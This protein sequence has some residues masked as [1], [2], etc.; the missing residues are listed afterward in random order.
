MGK[1]EKKETK[2]PPSDV[3]DTLT[4]DAQQAATC[5]LMLE[6]GEEDVLSK[7]CEALYKFVEKGDE[8]KKTLLDLGA[9]D[10]LLKLLQHDDRMV[11][12]NACMVFGLMTSHPDVRKMLRKRED[13]IPCLI[14]LISPE[15]DTLCHEFSA[16]ALSSLS[17]DYANKVMIYEN[18][19]MEAL[20]RCLGASDPDVQKNSVDA[21]SSLLQDFQARTAIRD[22]NGIAPILELTKSEYPVIQEIALVALERLTQDAENRAA[23]RELNGLT[24][25]VQFIGN[26]EFKDLHVFA[27]VVLSNC[28][29]DLES[30][31]TIKESGGLTKLVAYITDIPPPEDDGEKKKAGGKEKGK[32]AKSDKKGKVEETELVPTLPDVKQHAAKAIGRAAKSTEN[33]KVLHEAEVEKMFIHLFNHED[34]KVQAAAVEALGVM[35]EFG[36]SRD[37][38]SKWEGMEPLVKML[39]KEDLHELLEAAT[40]ALANLT[41]GSANN[42][43]EIVNFGGVESLIALLSH[44]KDTVIS[45][46]CVI[47]TNMSTQ[48]D[49][50]NDIQKAGIISALLTPLNSQNC[51]V[52]AKAAMAVASFVIDVDCRTDFRNIGG[53][54]PLVAML[55][56]A[57]DSVRRNSSWAVSICAVDEPTAMVVASLGG[58]ETL[59]AIQLSSSRKNAFTEAALDRLLNHNLSAKYALTGFLGSDNLI[60]DEFYDCG[61]LSQGAHVKPLTSLLEDDSHLFQ[62]VDTEYVLRSMTNQIQD[63]FY[64]MGATRP[65]PKFQPLEALCKKEVDQKRP[66]L[67]INPA[68]ERGS[69]PKP[70]LEQTIKDDVKPNTKGSRSGRDSKSPEVK[71]PSRNVT[72]SSKARSRKEK[73][74]EK[75]REEEEQR[76]R[77]AEEASQKENDKPFVPPADPQLLKYID[78]VNEK[79]M[80]LPTTRE[81][82]V[83]LARFVASKM[84]GA[85]ARG[86]VAQFSW[87]LPISQ[88]KYERKSNVLPIG[89][90]KTGIHLHRALLFKALGDRIGVG[91]TLERGEYNRAWNT[92]LLFDDDE[93]GKIKFPP[94]SFIVDTMHEPGE[95]LR[96]DTPEAEQYK[97]L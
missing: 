54:V 16:L 51:D 70:P 10:H 1:K 69:S 84:G 33:K 6:S 11:R 44:S 77:E 61:R 22:Q 95:L 28:L 36:L 45:N 87:E 88:L 15:E 78:E 4:I 23:F 93:N 73:D 91:C 34:V 41:E 97:R 86:Q 63:G 7:A 68:P 64:D 17:H 96:A 43:R 81:Q 50:R 13:T 62:H 12:R 25:L 75:E 47:L 21:I 67:L 32:G 57:D 55:E 39:K 60:G 79:I 8:N 90:I 29:E 74:E 40:L 80:P 89:A 31:E 20:I 49:V 35:A 94:K 71:K 59:Q 82:V 18:D 46:T 3:F 38:I 58:I 2:A 92:V 19:G 52:Q 14:S 48:E 72:S 27:V 85:I 9:V 53:L 83:A 5:I 24:Q 56:S 37:S 65:G 42:I 76:L 30:V 66:V 26:P